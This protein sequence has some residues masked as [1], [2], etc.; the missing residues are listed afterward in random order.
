MEVFNIFFQVVKFQYFFIASFVMSANWFLFCPSK[1]FN[2][3]LIYI[4]L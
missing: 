4:G 3:P 2:K 1:K